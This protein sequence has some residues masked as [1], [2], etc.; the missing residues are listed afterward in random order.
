[1]G[2]GK[3][4][5]RQAV[6]KWVKCVHPEAR[7]RV[8]VERGLVVYRCEDCLRQKIVRWSDEKNEWLVETNWVVWWKRSESEE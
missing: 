8:E 1:M 6:M 3:A 5:K 4:T 2:E 7:V